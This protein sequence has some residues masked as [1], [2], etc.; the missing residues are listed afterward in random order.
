MQTEPPRS[1]V[2]TYYDPPYLEE[3]EHAALDHSG[4]PGVG[5]GGSVVPIS[6]GFVGLFGGDITAVGS[7]SPI[8]Y[9]DA[10]LTGTDMSYSTGIVTIEETGVY[11]ATTY[12]VWTLSPGDTGPR[13]ISIVALNAGAEF[14][15]F[16]FIIGQSAGFIAEN[17]GQV[18]Y[19]QIPV[20][21][22]LPAGAGIQVQLSNGDPIHVATVSV[23]L[24]VSRVI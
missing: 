15:T 12:A 8:I 19:T 14:A 11:T 16:P 24:T 6:T 2:T 18:A 1:K 22:Y 20:T 7:I 9:D 23:Y 21:G 17:S 5:S 13:T 3:S 4:I 10:L